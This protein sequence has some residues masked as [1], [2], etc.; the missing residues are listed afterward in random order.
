MAGDATARLGA[1]TSGRTRSTLPPSPDYAEL[2]HRIRA[3]GLLEPQPRYFALKF[4]STALLYAINVA[5]VLVVNHPAVVLA[6]A[7]FLGLV[8]T[9][10]GFLGHDLAHRQITHRSRLVSSLGLIIGNLLIGVSYSWWTAKH[11]QHHATPNHSEQ[12]PD[13]DY[14][15]LVFE[16]ASIQD[17][18]R[19][20]YP[21]IAHQA[22]LYPFLG[23]FQAF[24][25]RAQ[26]VAQVLSGRSPRR[27][28]EG[29]AL[30]LH[31]LLYVALLIQ[32]GQWGLGLAF[33]FIHQMTFGLYN[34]LVFAP[35]HKGMPMIDESNR[36]DYL[37]EQVLT[38]RNV[39]AHPVIDFLY[40]GLN[41]Q[42]EH[43]LFPAM[44]RNRLRAAQPLVRAFCAER[45]IDYAVTGPLQGLI[46]PLRHLHRVS[47]P[48]R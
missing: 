16:S 6:A 42:I 30:A 34:T 33:L 26:A 9:H 45:G 41:Y 25:M 13:L 2:K 20:F 43:H 46:E 19:R 21:V 44:A 28:A 36:M 27:T 1:A 37:R 22:F 32:I 8:F 7:V 12:D 11:N 18:K 39:T 47:A 24:G 29:L 38:A 31:A 48:L 4:A 17:R 5:V 23:A 35:N 14:P 40:G 3:A 15:M 10:V